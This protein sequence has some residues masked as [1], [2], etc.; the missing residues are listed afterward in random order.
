MRFLG[1]LLGVVFLIS[2]SQVPIPSTYP[3]S[4]QQ[5]MQAAKHWDILAVD[6]AEQ[7]SQSLK[8]KDKDFIIDKGIY[9]QTQPGVF[10]N[11]FSE[12]LITHLLQNGI[13]VSRNNE[14]L[15]ILEY[16]AQV[17][18]HNEKFYQTYPGLFTAIAATVRVWHD[19]TKDYIIPA[20]I[21]LDFGAGTIATL[22]QSEVMITASLIKDDQYL[23]KQTNL[24]YIN[25]KDWRH[26]PTHSIAEPDQDMPLKTFKVKGE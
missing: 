7:V 4:S 9:V 26:Y 6:V 23:F 14:N 24:Y 11:A 1:G 17:I 21:L 18:K 13:K 2:C 3:F 12:M 16:K 19:F 22:P 8:A 25:D 20:G 15:P 10:G 5:K